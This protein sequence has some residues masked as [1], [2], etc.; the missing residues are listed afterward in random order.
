MPKNILASVIF[1]FWWCFFGLIWTIIATV[2]VVKT[3]KKQQ[4]WKRGIHRKLAYTCEKSTC[5]ALIVY[6]YYKYP[7]TKRFYIIFQAYATFIVCFC[8]MFVVIYDPASGI[9]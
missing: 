9:D 3:R 5:T 8:L 1:L 2:A 7:K 4:E 6:K